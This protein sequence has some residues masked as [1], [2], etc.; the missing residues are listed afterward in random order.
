[1]LV[2]LEYISMLKKLNKGATMIE[3]ALIASLIAVVAITVMKNVGI[4]IQTKMGKVQEELERTEESESTG[5][6]TTSGSQ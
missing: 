3:Y 4:G 6:E 2:K 1:M 5:G